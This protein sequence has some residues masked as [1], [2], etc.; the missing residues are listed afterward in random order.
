MNG[1]LDL[2]E[3]LKLINKKAA[4]ISYRL[5][6]LRLKDDTRINMNFFRVFIMPSY[7][8]AFT[9]YGHLNERDKEKL[10]VHM[11]VWIKKFIRVPINTANHTFRLIAGDLKEEV[12]QS[13]ARTRAKLLERETG[14]SV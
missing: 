12:V 5:Y 10:E 3:H 7:R 1:K 9:A 6:G 4:F 13:I 11:R 2:R 14:R 8:M